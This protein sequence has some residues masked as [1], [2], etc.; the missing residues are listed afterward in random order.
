VPSNET[1]NRTITSISYRKKKKQ[2]EVTFGL[3]KVVLSEDR[4][5]DYYLYVGK[6]VPAFTFHQLEREAN[7]EKLYQ[8]AVKLAIGG[9][10]SS[11]EVWQKINAKAQVGQNPKEIYARLKKNGLLD[12]ASYAEDYAEMKSAQGYGKE[13]ILYELQEIKRVD[14]AILEKLE[15]PDEET[16]AK[17]Y[18]VTIAPHFARFPLSK[19]KEKAYQALLRRGFSPTLARAAIADYQEDKESTSRSL[20]RDFTTLYARYA[21]QYQYYELRKHLFDGLL[22]KGYKMEA[23]QER[24]EEEQC[25]QSKI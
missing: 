12:D 16:K 14:P 18:A 25:K 1:G 22:R 3:E 11:Y 7:E 20:E 10:R 8:Y 9:S 23:I 19:K 13:R 24:W 4:F 5:T 17:E 2:Y 6:E 21:R 15:F